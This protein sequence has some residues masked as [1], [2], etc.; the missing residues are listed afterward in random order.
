[1]KFSRQILLKDDKNFKYYCFPGSEH[2]IDEE[3]APLLLKTYGNL[4]EIFKTN[5][6]KRIKSVYVARGLKIN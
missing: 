6:V 3:Y 5:F 1:M 2:M 4:D